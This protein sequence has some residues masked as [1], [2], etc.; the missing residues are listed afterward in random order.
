MHHDQQDRQSDQRADDD[1][2]R[3][4]V[5]TAEAFE[6]GILDGKGEDAE[7]KRGNADQVAGTDMGG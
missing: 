7:R 3:D 5:I 4:R 6:N 1:R 2:Q